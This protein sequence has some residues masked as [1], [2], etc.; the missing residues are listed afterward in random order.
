[1]SLQDIIKRRQQ[2][3]F[4]GREERLI[5]FRTNLG[6]PVVDRRFLF[7][8]HGDAGVGKTFLMNQLRRIAEQHGA[9]CGYIDESSYGVPEALAS[10]AA[11]LA[12]G[13][14]RLTRFER[15]YAA[16]RRRR[17]ELDADPDTPAGLSETFTKGALQVGLHSA[18][19]LP[20]LGVAAEVVD[21]AAAAEQIDR[22]RVFVGQKFRNHDDA[23]LVLSPAEALTPVFLE[24]LCTLAKRK[25]VALFFD[26]YERT[27]WFLDTWLLDLFAARYGDLPADLVIT[28]AGRSAL[29]GNHWT[30]YHSII[31]DVPLTSFTD[32]EGR[33][34]LARQNVTGDRVVEVIL[35]LSG[36][37]PLLVAMLAEGRPDNPADVGDRTGDA[38]ERFLKWEPDGR[39]RATALAGALPRRLNE[40]VLAAA[41]DADDDR[42]ELFEW[43][44]TQPFLAETA[45]V[46]QYHD[47]VRMPMLRLQRN[48]SP[49][50]WRKQHR[51]LVEY[52]RTERAALGLSDENGWLDATWQD[53]HLEETYHALC[54]DS[55]A[56]LPDALNHAVFALSDSTPTARRWVDTMVAA[57]RDS[58]SRLVRTWGERLTRI[59]PD[60]HSDEI[61]FLTALID[62]AELEPAAY[63]KAL[64]LRGDEH[65]LSG[66][67]DQ[68]LADFERALELDQESPKAL[69]GRGEVYRLMNRYDH[70]LADFTR[71]IEL[72]PQYVWAIASRAYLHWRMGRHEVALADFT[73]AINLNPGYHWSITLRGDMYRRLG[74]SERTLAL[75][76]RTGGFDVNDAFTI[77]GR[78]EVF[79]LMGRY[80]EALSEFN[81][82]IEREPNFSRAI[83]NR[84]ETYFLMGRYDHA[85][86]DLDRAI[87]LDPGSSFP[88]YLRGAVMVAQGNPDR[89]YSDIQEAVVLAQ[90]EMRDEP[91]EVLH[92][93]HLAIYRAALGDWAEARQLLLDFLDRSQTPWF[94]TH[95]L[96]DLRELSQLPGVSQQ[97]VQELIRLVEQHGV[98]ED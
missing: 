19:M 14:A 27:E 23:Q 50:R 1:M 72:D 60:E 35:Q 89:G 38:V 96:F 59:L 43:L 48:R 42:S 15:R 16:Y 17:H 54:A 24:D 12:Q 49:Q 94:A 98:A 39:R 52:Y 85:I 74:R 8:V 68:A 32:A 3:D 30:S 34:F 41:C 28:V 5:E 11:D 62:Y 37:L 7:N 22:L 93:C 33:T 82:I 61:A 91:A 21:V 86:I 58:D 47:V 79:W 66:Q 55:A 92:S 76:Q 29:D 90:R 70:A 69:A 4:V 10:L 20:I 57:G 88:Q 63:E 46:W 51:R 80:E 95:A 26:T 78:G 65:R 77:L 75:A 67:F 25:T 71:A 81:R 9:F 53:C 83:S 40:D 6:L 56:A 87:E 84:A 44:R 18:K 13:G 97:R 73:R 2:A 36:R 64:Q 31:A 45:G